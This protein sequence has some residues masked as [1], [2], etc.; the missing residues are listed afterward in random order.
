MKKLILSLLLVGM[1]TGSFAENKKSK[2][3]G[4]SEAQMVTMLSGQIIDHETNE[5]L[6]GVKVVLDETSEVVYTDFDGNYRFEK[7]PVGE[8][9]LK[10]SYVSYNESTIGEVQVC[11][12]NNQVDI[13]LKTVN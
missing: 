9:S 12:E 5:A 8:H 4:N 1:I 2:N 11:S 7:V 3:E 13:R 6:V 10:A